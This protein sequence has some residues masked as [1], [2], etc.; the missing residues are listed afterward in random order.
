MPTHT[1]EAPWL[2]AVALTLTLAAQFTCQTNTS[3][4]WHV[5]VVKCMVGKRIEWAGAGGQSR[6]RDRDLVGPRNLNI[7]CL[8]VVITTIIPFYFNSKAKKKDMDLVQRLN[9]Q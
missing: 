8:L 9:T 2:Q 6:G 1:S 4:L 7:S 3:A 5:H